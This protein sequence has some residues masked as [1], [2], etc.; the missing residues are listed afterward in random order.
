MARIEID[1]VVVGDTLAIDGVVAVGD[2]VPRLLARLRAY[3]DDALARLRGVIGVGIVVVLGAADALP[4]ID[5][6]RYIAR[7]PDEP[8]LLLP[9]GMRTRLAPQIVLR[10]LLDGTAGLKPPIVLV[11]ESRRIVSLADARTIAR[12]RLE[13]SHG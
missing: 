12:A 1:P 10:A 11:P 3:D 9:T 5:G 8:N 4:W 7:A 6:A 2:A 13:P